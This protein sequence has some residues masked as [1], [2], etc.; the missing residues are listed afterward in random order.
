MLAVLDK[1]VAG[2]L[3]RVE[4]VAKTRVQR[5]ELRRHAI[6]T[7]ADRHQN[8]SFLQYKAEQP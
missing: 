7:V 2:Y 6:N 8:Q 3:A 5:A 4:G 1:A